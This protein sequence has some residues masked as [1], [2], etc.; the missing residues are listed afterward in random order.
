MTSSKPTAPPP[1]SLSV[2][3][4]RALATMDNVP[5]P[6]IS[7]CRMSP[8]TGLCEGCHRTLEELRAWSRMSD[9]QKRGVWALLE[10][11]ANPLEA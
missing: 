1:L 5:S 10:A 8:T 3:A 11:R 2:R 9:A 4:A 6:C 7:V